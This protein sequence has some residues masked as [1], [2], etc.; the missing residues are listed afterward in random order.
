MLNNYFN[1]ESERLY[2]RKLIESDVETWVHFFEKNPNPHFLGL[3]PSLSHRKLATDWINR[4]FER[5]DSEGF[6][7]LA[8]IEKSSGLHIGM[9]GILERQIEGKKH[10]EIAYSL[11]PNSWNKGYGTEIALNF[12]KY[13]LENNIADKFISIIHKDNIASQKVALKNGMKIISEIN[14]M[15]IDAFLFETEI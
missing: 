13:G 6:G 7:H 4:Q 8:V 2:F 14:F 3:D 9:G 15:G 1:Q 12:K 10:F 11:M 5:Y